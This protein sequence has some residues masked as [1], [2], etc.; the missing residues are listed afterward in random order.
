MSNDEPIIVKIS[1][2]IEAHGKMLDELELQ[3]PKMKHM[4]ARDDAT[5]QIEATIKVVASLAGVPPS[6]IEELTPVDFAKV[7]EALRPF[8][9]PLGAEE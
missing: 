5:G 8:F 7:E 6:S 9:E 4:K 2:P 1:D 3:R